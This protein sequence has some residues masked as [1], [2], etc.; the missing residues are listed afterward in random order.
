[1]RL[2]SSSLT[3]FSGEA[4]WGRTHASPPGQPRLLGASAGAAPGAASGG[5]KQRGSGGGGALPGK[6]VRGWGLS[7]CFRLAAPSCSSGKKASF[8][9]GLEKM[10]G[11]E[12]CPLSLHPCDRSVFHPTAQTALLWLMESFANEFLFPKAKGQ[13]CYF[14]SLLQ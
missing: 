12:V 4:W 1:M 5:G 8:S 11:P 14:F 10:W 3:P 2:M 9:R 7:L 6:M 13:F